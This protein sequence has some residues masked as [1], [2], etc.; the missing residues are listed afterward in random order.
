M[1][2]EN[3]SECISCTN[4]D[5]VIPEWLAI[6]ELYKFRSWTL[7]IWNSLFYVRVFAK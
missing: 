3:M 6:A 7:S 5:S 2:A 4:N 1:I